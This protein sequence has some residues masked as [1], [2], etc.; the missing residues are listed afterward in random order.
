MGAAAAGIIG[1]QKLARVKT[2]AAAAFTTKSHKL[3][4]VRM[5]AAAAG[6]KANDKAGP[7]DV[8]GHSLPVAS[9]I[10]KY[11]YACTALSSKADTCS[12]CN[13]FGRMC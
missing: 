10:T 3:T 2:K 12:K 7:N 4:R 9:R 8:K 6:S 13:L 11:Q 1:F 5:G